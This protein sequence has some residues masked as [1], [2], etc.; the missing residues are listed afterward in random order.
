MEN[1]LKETKREKKE[2]E[3]ELQKKCG[4]ALMLIATV[5]ILLGVIK[6]FVPAGFIG[7]L[8]FAGIIALIAIASGWGA[9]E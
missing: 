7:L 9:D 5:G 2:K 8:I 3:K 1:E 4:V 6:G